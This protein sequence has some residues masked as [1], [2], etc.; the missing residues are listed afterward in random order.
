MFLKVR[1]AMPVWAR[2]SKNS[3]N[4]LKTLSKHTYRRKGSN[5]Y[6]YKQPVQLT[7]SL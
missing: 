4:N 5:H 6:A 7:K 1:I 2:Q 3:K